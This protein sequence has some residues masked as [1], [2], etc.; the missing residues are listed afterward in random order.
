MLFGKYIY[1]DSGHDCLCLCTEQPPLG[2]SR[3]NKELEF[4]PFRSIPLE[5]DIN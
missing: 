3:D 1:F 5:A 4:V 2:V